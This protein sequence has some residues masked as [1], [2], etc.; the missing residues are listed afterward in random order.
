MQRSSGPRGRRASL[1]TVALA[2][3]SLT[4]MDAEACQRLMPGDQN[5]DINRPVPNLDRPELYVT[6]DGGFIDNAYDCP[7]GQQ[8]FVIDMPLAGLTYVRD[9]TYDGA[10]FAA[11]RMSERSPL[12][13]F[14]YQL[15]SP[16]IPS[17]VWPLRAGLNRIPGL[18]L[19]SATGVDAG[20]L[21]RVFLAGGAM[22]SVPY[23]HLGTIVSWPENDPT[24]RLLHSVAMGFNVPVLTCS[25][26][27]RAVALADVPAGELATVGSTAKDTSVDMSMVCPSANVDVELSLADANDASNVGAAL[28]PAATSTASGVRVQL[29]RAGAPV[30]LRQ[31]WRYGYSSKGDQPIAFTAR[32]VRTADA[33]QPGTIIGEAVLTATYR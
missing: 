13:G 7:P 12:I 9:I 15:K 10:T 5:L 20:V 8:A 14:V 3:L 32:Y 30:Q 31:V 1:L 26:S 22:E 24:Q 27:D 23:H 28:V 11:Y 19:S 33:L 25:L 17:M 16:I 4:S 2:A 18:A 21:A 6:G 29:M